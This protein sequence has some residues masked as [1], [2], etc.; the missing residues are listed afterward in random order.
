MASEQ[1]SVHLFGPPA[2][3]WRGQ[4]FSVPT[5]KSTA[6]LCYVALRGGAPRPELT[7]LL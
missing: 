2:F 7:E 3:V 5:R 4:S 1:L 6:L